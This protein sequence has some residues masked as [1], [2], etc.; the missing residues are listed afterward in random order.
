MP[1]YNIETDKSN[2]KITKDY[3]KASRLVAYI[4]IKQVSLAIQ[5]SPPPQRVEIFS[6]FDK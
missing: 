3:L 2:Y 5:L 4:Q 1:K 6:I